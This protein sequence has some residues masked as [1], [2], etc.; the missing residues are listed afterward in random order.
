MPAQAGSIALSELNQNT[1]YFDYCF[2]SQLC[3]LVNSCFEKSINTDYENMLLFTE[4]LI[5]KQC[6][7]QCILTRSASGD[8]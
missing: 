8:S 7:K 5:T 3:R 4:L 1:F 2:Y 6:I